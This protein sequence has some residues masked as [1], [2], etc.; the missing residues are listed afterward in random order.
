MTEDYH[1]YCT[2]CG[3]G[4]SG[5]E[6]DY[7]EYC[8]KMVC[9]YCPDYLCSNGPATVNFNFCY[10]RNYD[11]NESAHTRTYATNN[12]TL[13]L[14]VA[15]TVSGTGFTKASVTGI[16]S[17]NVTVTYNSKG[18]YIITITNAVNAEINIVPVSY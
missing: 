8:G 6:Y 17:S 5:T 4:I 2:H 10:D 1:D 11:Y 12:G 15:S 7:C 14:E 18:Y 9:G 3:T 16:D 13:T